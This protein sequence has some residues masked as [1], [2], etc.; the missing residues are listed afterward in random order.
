M[1]KL[2]LVAVV[3]VKV[4][5]DSYATVVFT[6]GEDHNEHKHHHLDFLWYP[7]T[8]YLL[9]I[10]EISPIQAGCQKS[11]LLPYG[12]PP[13]PKAECDKKNPF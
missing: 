4:Q 7:W 9:Q 10:S 13:C 1:E 6:N 11:E 5:N 3:S 8:V 2:D 12:E